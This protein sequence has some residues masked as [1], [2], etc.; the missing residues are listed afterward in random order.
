MKLDALAWRRQ[1][2]LG[3]APIEAGLLVSPAAPKIK[4]SVGHLGCLV[5]STLHCDFSIARNSGGIQRIR[6]HFRASES[7]RSLIASSKGLVIT[8]VT[9]I[10]YNL[11]N[12]MMD[13]SLSA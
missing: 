4:V 3:V 9:N 11:T 2:D 13:D 6:S 7:R 5:V 1:E 8:R 10:V 12:Y